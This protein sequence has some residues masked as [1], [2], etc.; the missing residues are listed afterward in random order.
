MCASPVAMASACGCAGSEAVA[1][2]VGVLDAPGELVGDGVFVGLGDGVFVGLGDAL[3]SAVAVGA[4]RSCGE[5][6]TDIAANAA[7]VYMG[8]AYVPS[9]GN[10]VATKVFPGTSSTPL[11]PWSSVPTI[12]LNDG[13]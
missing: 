10:D 12:Q 5:N 6:A 11:G 13:W 1:V 4:G 9:Q 3:D 7:T 2:G 8:F